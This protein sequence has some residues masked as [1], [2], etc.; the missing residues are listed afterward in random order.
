MMEHMLELDEKQKDAIMPVVEKYAKENF[1]LM[2]NFRG[3]FSVLMKE[4]H[5]ELTPH[6]NPEQIECLNEFGKRGREMRRREEFPRYGRG[7]SGRGHGSDQGSG[8]GQGRPPE[9]LDW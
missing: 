3:E 5:K 9:S 8:R 2:K 7:R 6:L 4:F 1:E